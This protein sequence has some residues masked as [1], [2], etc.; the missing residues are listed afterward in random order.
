MS[1]RKLPELETTSADDRQRARLARWLREWR[2]AVTLQDESP[3]MG[4]APVIPGSSGDRPVEA[5]QVRLL[6]PCGPVT[7]VRPVHVAILRAVGRDASL[8]APFG[9]FAEPAV[10]GE[11]LTGRTAAPLRVLC[12]WNGREWPAGGLEQSW[13]VTELTADECR[14]AD[15]IG[16]S[17]A[18]GA[19]I[20][21]DLRRATGPPLVHPDDPRQVYIARERLAIERAAAELGC[22]YELPRR[23]ELPRAAEDRESYETGKNGD[24]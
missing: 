22:A 8:A 19:S 2:I 7:R 1:A 14:A 10:P 4:E 23:S 20:P 18:S 13:F 9:R 11:W 17:L 3:G 12:V 5:G 15:R 24:R 6:M 21:A 16:E